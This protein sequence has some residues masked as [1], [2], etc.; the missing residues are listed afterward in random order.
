ME[1]SSLKISKPFS[2]LSFLIDADIPWEVVDDKVQRRIVGYDP[3]LMIVKYKFRKGGI[4]ALHQ[5]IHSQS[6][7]VMR[8]VFELTING[9][10]KILKAGDG[11]MVDP[12]LLHRALCLE[13]RIL[14]DA[15]NPVW[16]EWLKE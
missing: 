13:D 12:N 14:L 11:Y 15:F 1:N 5:H 6:A 7:V 8:G 16:E 9:Q 3:D 4:G 2:S 10:K